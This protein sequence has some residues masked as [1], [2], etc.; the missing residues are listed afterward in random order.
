MI[1][2][3]YEKANESETLPIDISEIVSFIKSH[4][5]H[6]EISFYEV[7]M[8]AGIVRGFMRHSEGLPAPYCEPPSFVEIYYAKGQEEYW[9]SLVKCK[10]LMHLFDH[11]TGVAS[12]RASVETLITQIVIPPDLYQHADPAIV[13]T[14][15]LIWAL[16]IL[17]PRKLRDQLSIPY[18]AGK[19]SA[20][21]I[22]KIAQIPNR[23]IAWMMSPSYLRFVEKYF[24]GT[25]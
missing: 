3:I 7:E 13:D 16:A 8:D 4:G 2:K 18:A 15:A 1:R 12:D 14:I 23:F 5:V 10:E 20:L 17:F 24:E 9:S 21:E 22:A 6:D 11:T 19:I 25:T